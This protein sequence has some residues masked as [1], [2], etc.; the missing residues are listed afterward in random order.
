MPEDVVVDR[1][2]VDE[3]EVNVDEVLQMYKLDVF[4]KGDVKIRSQLR[5]VGH[6]SE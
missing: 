6:R 5:K 2:V 1:V 3:A 4:V